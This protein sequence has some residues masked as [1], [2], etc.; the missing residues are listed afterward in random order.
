MITTARRILSDAGFERRARS[1]DPADPRPVIAGAERRPQFAAL[2]SADAFLVQDMIRIAETGRELRSGWGNDPRTAARRL[3]RDGGYF[4]KAFH[5][6][7]KRLYAGN[8]M[9]GLSS[10]VLVEATAALAGPEARCDV[11]LEWTGEN[12]DRIFW[13]PDDTAAPPP[14]PSE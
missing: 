6:R 2:L 12:G 11:K 1:Y 4:I 7:L 8:E 10:L 13:T 14:N 9:L 5:G 3:A